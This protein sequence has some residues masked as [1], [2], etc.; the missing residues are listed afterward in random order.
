MNG[1]GSDQPMTPDDGPAGGGGA[2]R[3]RT[4]HGFL[5]AFGSA[6]GQAVLQIGSLAILGRLL[7]P[8][9]YG[10]VA[11]SMLA[12]GFTAMLGQLG[13][14]AAVVQKPELTR[15]QATA[16][17]YLSL[18]ATVLLG[19]VFWL[20]APWLNVLVGLPPDSVA[21]RLLAFQL[22]IVGLTV[23]PMG[24]LQRA[25][26]F[27]AMAMVET[28]SYA[29]GSVGVSIG[30]ALA[31]AGALA[32]V[33][34]QLTN[35]G[36]TAV[37]YLVL[38]RMSWALQGPRRLVA[39][40]RDLL[41]FGLSYSLGQIANWVA[42]NGDNFIVAN[43]LTTASLGVYGRAYQLLAQPA[44]LVGGVADKV[45]FPAMSRV[46]GD[47][48]RMARAYVS[49]CAFVALATVPASVVLCVAAP[50]IIRI[51][52][53]PNWAGVVLPLQLFALVL[54]PRTSYKISGSFTRARGAVLGGSLRQW[55]YAAEVII[56]CAIGS[57]WGVVGVAA[58]AG[59][60]I[61]L[62]YLTMVH[63]SAQVTKGLWRRLGRAYLRY[64]PI[65]VLAVGAALLGRLVTAG[66]G[67]ALLTL[68]AVTGL[69]LAATA[70]V[71]VV[72]RRAFAEELS[73]LRTIAGL[74]PVRR[75]VP[76]LRRRGDRSPRS[77]G[78]PAS[79]DAGAR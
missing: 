7:S 1:T 30:L 18:S 29:I 20:V 6:G 60:A 3:R 27:R 46:Q 45:L 63:F 38:S 78:R 57:I 17:L 61:T 22:P 33:F 70:L 62:H 50:E 32:L 69:V 47:P 75:L 43:R 24:L 72:G 77:G 79:G 64:I 76:P 40:T 35:V 11:A 58:G 56:G 55:L 48:E 2:L 10:V 73:L 53:G 59:V 8:H 41:R 67:S 26:R 34:G 23:V 52:L 74:L 4:T 36:L 49:A 9:E 31:G 15:E 39:N 65:A 12:V 21:I 16:A 51:L 25:L 13:V 28:V 54:L 68:V 66:A 14:S 37:G 44:N 42:I 19:V 5:W 71:L